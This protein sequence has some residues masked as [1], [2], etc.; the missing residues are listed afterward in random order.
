MTV[1]PPVDPHVIRWLVRL[2]GSLQVLRLLP[3]PALHLPSEQGRPYSFLAAFDALVDE[4]G[5]DNGAAGARQ[6]LVRDLRLDHDT[7]PLD[8]FSDV[9]RWLRCPKRREGAR[10]EARFHG[11]PHLFGPTIHSALAGYVETHAHLRASVP[12][13]H[14]WAVWLCDQRRRA[15]LSQFEVRAGGWTV[16]LGD[17]VTAAEEARRRQTSTPTPRLDGD[18][19]AKFIE[20]LAANQHQSG[21]ACLYLLVCGVVRRYFVYQRQRS[22]LATFTE[23]YECF[24]KAQKPR[25]TGG[26]G[27]EAELVKAALDRFV[28]HG[29][30]VVELRPTF[31]RTAK[32]LVRRL[33]G[34]VLGY[35]D[36]IAS[37]RTDPPAAMGLVLSLFKQQPAADPAE[38]CA[39]WVSQVDALTQILDDNAVFRRFVVGIDAA[40]R[41]RG[42][43]PWALRPAIDRIRRWNLDRGVGRLRPGGEVGVAELRDRLQAAKTTPE[44]L[45]DALCGEF[46]PWRRLGVTVHAGED[47]ADPMTG[48]R[49]LWEALVH[50]DLREG[51]RVGHALALALTTSPKPLLDQL[52][53]RR[54]AEREATVR[55]T[56]A[57]FLVWKPRGE[58]LADLAWELDMA[59]RLA[60]D[61]AAAGARLAAAAS[62]TWGTLD[63]A[64]QLAELLTTEPARPRWTAEVA[65]AFFADPRRIP[66]WE[67]EWVTIDPDWRARF[68]RYRKR[69]VAEVVRRRVVIESCPTSNL[70]VA[71]L[72]EPPIGVL[73]GIEGLRCVAST[74]DPGLFGAWPADEFDLVD[75]VHHERLLE[76]AR[77]AAFCR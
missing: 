63:R 14:L 76:E 33:R 44:T 43:P 47:F 54:C 46:A 8:G 70:V 56:G 16:T 31:E 71:N 7:C 55:R 13:I 64:P 41:E 53:E 25:S 58:H 65:G 11:L 37:A 66:E 35:L 48:L 40:G 38:R 49:H 9:L 72:N 77:L 32:D 26:R 2:T 68:E 24:S 15:A 57:G 22:G 27:A 3:D 19:E 74:D 73:L 17:L 28:R 51:D 4:I 5:V 59:H 62:R 69:V 61:E 42:S 60:T 39:I 52:L 75:R 34:C 6:V 36:H 45:F 50:L 10:K 20:G 29:A 21:D 1:R 30:T 12:F 18:A 23:S 67:R